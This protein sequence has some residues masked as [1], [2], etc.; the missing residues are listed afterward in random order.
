[1]PLPTHV[2]CI[3]ASGLPDSLTEGKRYPLVKAFRDYEGGPRM[4]RI[5]PNDHPNATEQVYAW[6]FREFQEERR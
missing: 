4:L 6:R 1:M 5:V 2:T 3:D